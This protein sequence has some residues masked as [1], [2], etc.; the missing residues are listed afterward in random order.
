MADC[1]LPS[2]CKQNN[3]WG[4]AHLVVDE[5]E[6]ADVK[7]A[8]I[9]QG[10]GWV[11]PVTDPDT[12]TDLN[13][14]WDQ[15]VPK[16]ADVSSGGFDLDTATAVT[17]SFADGGEVNLDR[18]MDM[19]NL[20][21]DKHYYRS[22]KMVSFANSPWGYQAGTPDQY[23]PA[24]VMPIRSKKNVS[25][26]MMSQSLVAFTTLHL[27]DIDAS[28]STYSSEKYWMQN[29]YV[30]VVLEQAWQYLVGLVEAGAETP[31]EDAATTIQAIVEPEPVD[32]GTR[33]V[34][35][36]TNITA[37]ATFDITV[38]GRREVKIVSGSPA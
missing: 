22:R 10:S 31:W 35:W 5:S 2:E 8:G 11:V 1:P 32:T 28:R 19:S 38:P 15:L 26:D 16:D 21:D 9:F 14:L 12:A 6:T 25:A 36:A 30:D 13:T 29:K 7:E 20:D 24:Q 37:W 18:L 4:E 17:S 33:L 27:T 23:Y 3:V 34:S